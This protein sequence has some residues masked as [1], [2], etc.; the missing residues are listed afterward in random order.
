[1]TF[2][3]NSQKSARAGEPFGGI[4]GIIDTMK[5]REKDEREL[6]DRALAGEAIAFEL[7]AQQHA[8]RL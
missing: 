8:E 4:R 5:M 7:L 2:P 3:G 6:I 1:M